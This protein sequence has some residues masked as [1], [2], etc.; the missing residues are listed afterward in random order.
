[1]KRVFYFECESAPHVLFF[2]FFPPS[3]RWPPRLHDFTLLCFSPSLLITGD[4]WV[5]VL[6][7]QLGARHRINFTT[8][9]LNGVPLTFNKAG[10]RGVEPALLRHSVLTL[11]R[12]RFASSFLYRFNPPSG[13]TVF[14]FLTS[15]APF[16][17]P[18]SSLPPPPPPPSSAEI[19]LASYSCIYFI[20]K[21]SEAS[22]SL[23]LS[24]PSLIGLP[25]L[26]SS[27]T[28]SLYQTPLFC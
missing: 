10:R 18:R 5:L 7:S 13:S 24:P 8:A 4:K 23:F 25:L 12:F 27:S 19:R 15:S 16:C 20:K 3:Y 1:M 14:F 26:T 17:L 2:G 11:L 6:W 22:V 9:V 21:Q 28:A